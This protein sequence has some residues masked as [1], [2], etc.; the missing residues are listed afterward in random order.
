VSI[1]AGEATANLGEPVDFDNELE[2]RHYMLDAFGH[3]PGLIHEFQTP[4][5]KRQMNPARAITYFAEP[6]N[7]WSL[8]TVEANFKPLQNAGSYYADKRFDQYSVM[9][10]RLPVEV[11]NSGKV[12]E[13]GD[14]LSP[15]DTEFIRRP[16]P[17]R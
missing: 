14:Q 11:M 5:A 9:L 4:A 13:P 8:E 16:Y 12:F 1:P 10:H 2:S 7:S 17:G 15:G 6:P 3:V